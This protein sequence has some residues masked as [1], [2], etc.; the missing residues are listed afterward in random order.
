MLDYQ[1]YK[2]I[3]PMYETVND[4][5]LTTNICLILDVGT[6]EIFKLINKSLSY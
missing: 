1:V 4:D 6:L 3:K 2:S 5:D